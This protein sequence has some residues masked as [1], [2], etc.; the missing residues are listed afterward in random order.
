[1]SEPFIARQS[2]LRGLSIC[3]RRTFFDLQAGFD[4]TRGF[5]ESLADLGTVQHVVC[6]RILLTLYEQSETE[7]PTQEAVEIA[8]ETYGA[9]PIVLPAKD[10]DDLIGMTLRFV[11]RPKRV[12][13][14]VPILG[15][16]G[17]IRPAIE[18]RIDVSITCPD[19]KTRILSG[20][21]DAVFS[22]DD[23]RTAIIAD[24]K[25]SRAKPPTP[26]QQQ[27]GVPEDT[28]VGFDYLSKQGHFQGPTYSVLLFAKLPAVRRVIFREH[29]L[30]YGLFREF[31]MERG[32][33]KH[34][35]FSTMLGLHLM[36]LERA[37]Q[38]GEDSATWKPRPGGHCARQCPVARSC[39]VPEEQRGVGAI[40]DDE[41]AD[42]EAARFV[43]VDGLRDQLR[44]ALKE[45]YEATG[46]PHLVGD[47]TA[48][49]W[50]GGA[51]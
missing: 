7:M 35:R 27:D 31:I 43:M 40:E 17:E 26:R 45:R 30:R 29:Y 5:T 12:D 16:D 2:T 18:Q 47:G 8:N 39:P 25:S 11:E 44:L 15:D 38:E 36:K 24:W 23:A 4:A 28:A 34:E 51:R 6:A 14:L 22:A 19:G 48:L 46:R 20:Q 42:R 21:P 49:S 33:S 9:L 10:Y 13:R 32:D 50:G 41:S 37:L 3:G 1:M